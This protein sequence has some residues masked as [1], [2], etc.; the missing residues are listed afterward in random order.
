MTLLAATRGQLLSVGRS[1]R[2]VVASGICDVGGNAL[3]VLA[4]SGIQVSLAAALSGIYPLFTML[5]AR[6][7]LNERLPRLGLAGVALAL[8]AIVLIAVG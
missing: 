1:W 7:V 6:V 5:L 3:Y 4:R 8:L 2:L